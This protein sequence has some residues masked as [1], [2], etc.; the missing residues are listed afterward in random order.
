MRDRLRTGVVRV[1]AGESLRKV[2]AAQ[3]R[4]LA[5]GQAG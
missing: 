4:M 1:V 5:N 3:G 2:R